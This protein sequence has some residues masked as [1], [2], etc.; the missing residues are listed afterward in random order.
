MKCNEGGQTSEQVTEHL[1]T[2]WSL[3]NGVSNLKKCHHEVL[4]LECS[5][6]LTVSKQMIH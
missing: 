6:L 3:K 1:E 4:I 5:H 2:E